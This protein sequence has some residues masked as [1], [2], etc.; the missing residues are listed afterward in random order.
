MPTV[1]IHM[2]EG[3]TK[4]QKRN[5]VKSVTDA[6]V[7]SLDVKP[8]AVTIFLHEIS[9]ENVAKAGKIVAET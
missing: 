6:I 9:K 1:H 2:Y 5:L 7:K 4:E 8:E 3:R